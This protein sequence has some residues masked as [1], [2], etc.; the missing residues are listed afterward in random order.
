MDHLIKLA[1]EIGAA[2]LA[3]WGANKVV[4]KMTGRSIPEHFSAWWNEVNY[5]ISQWI[6]NHQHLKI[7]RV[8]ATIF[9]VID[10]FMVSA[11]KT[12]TM[13]FNAETPTGETTITNRT[14]SA[15]EALNLFPEFKHQ[16]KVP[17]PLTT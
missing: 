12:V 13:S 6:A 5:E 7:T 1:L 15:Q 10:R 14:L 17:I 4:T 3:A 11:N 9:T 2:A 16:T 8:V